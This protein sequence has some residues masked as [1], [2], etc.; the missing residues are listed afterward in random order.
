MADFVLYTT[1]VCKFCSEAKALLTRLGRTYEVRDAREEAN[2]AFLRGQGFTKVPQI[3]VTNADGSLGRHIGG[4]SDLRDEL[5][6][7]L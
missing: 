4:Y 5:V 1:Q 7:S 6:D 2:L 3:Y